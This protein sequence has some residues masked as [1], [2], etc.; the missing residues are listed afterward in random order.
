[1]VDRNNMRVNNEDKNRIDDKERY[2]MSIE[3]AGARGVTWW[4]DLVLCHVVS[5]S[6]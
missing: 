3:D 4:T 2:R 6:I 5:V 1:M